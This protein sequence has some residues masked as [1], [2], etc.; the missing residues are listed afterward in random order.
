MRY[1]LILA[2]LLTASRVNAQQLS[3]EAGYFAPGV[4]ASTGQP[5]QVVQL[6]VTCNQSFSIPAGSPKPT[7]PIKV[8]WD[9]PAVPTKACRA[10]LDTSTALASSPA[11]LDYQFGLRSADSIG[12]KSSWVVLPFDWR[13]PVLAPTGLRIGS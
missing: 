4:N 2:F 8:E 10:T 9:D 1:G 3:Y 11:G 13:K 6:T 5:I 12:T 7:N